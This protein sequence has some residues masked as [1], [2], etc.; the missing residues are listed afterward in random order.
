MLIAQLY[1][2]D[3]SPCNVNSASL[4]AFDCWSCNSNAHCAALL[5]GCLTLSC[6]LLPTATLTAQ[7]ES[8]VAPPCPP[9]RFC[10]PFVC[11]SVVLIVQVVSEEA[12][13]EGLSHHVCELQLALLPFVRLMVSHHV[14]HLQLALLLCLTAC[15]ASFCQQYSPLSASLCSA[16]HKSPQFTSWCVSSALCSLGVKRLVLSSVSQ[17]LEFL[18]LPVCSLKLAPCSPSFRV[19]PPSFS[20]LPCAP[21]SLVLPRIGALCFLNRR[22]VLP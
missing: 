2:W 15:T 7:L 8:W 12:V 21:S 22:L 4:V 18:P 19:N 5:L 3:A 17:R 16:R 13:R 11:R 1:C 9:S 14:C 20:L 6:Q 10:P